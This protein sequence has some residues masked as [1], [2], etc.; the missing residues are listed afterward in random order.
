MVNPIDTDPD[1]EAELGIE[2]VKAEQFVTYRQTIALRK[3]DKVGAALAYLQSRLHEGKVTG[4]V[5]C[6]NMNQGGI[7]QIQT[8]QTGRIRI[9][10]ELEALTDEAFAVT[11][12]SEIA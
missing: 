7:T 12:T 8:E 2:V 3:R 4:K 6:L 5:L 11:V 1:I 9:G 10:S